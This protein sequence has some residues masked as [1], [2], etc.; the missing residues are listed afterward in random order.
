MLQGFGRR[1]EWSVHMEHGLQATPT[2]RYSTLCPSRPAFSPVLQQVRLTSASSALCLDLC[3]THSSSSSSL[4][5]FLGVA[6]LDHPIWPAPSTSTP[7]LSTPHHAFLALQHFLIFAWLP[8][9]FPIWL[10]PVPAGTLFAICFAT[11]SRGP[12]MPGTGWALKICWINEFQ[13]MM[14]FFCSECI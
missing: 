4:C 5:H 7:S 11:A 6:S 9:I 1:S 2:N 13:L 14:S 3:S 10:S 12:E 8:S